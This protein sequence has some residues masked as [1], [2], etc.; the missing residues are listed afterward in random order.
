MV[1]P[2]MKGD[3]EV[4]DLKGKFDTAVANHPEVPRPGDH[5]AA[6]HPRAFR[7]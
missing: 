4:V 7:R 6:A 3:E 2:L 1:T 5:G